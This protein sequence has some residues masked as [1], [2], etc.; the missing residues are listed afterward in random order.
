[1][2]VAAGGRLTTQRPELILPP[3]FDGNRNCVQVGLHGPVNLRE[4]PAEFGEHGCI[5][6]PRRLGEGV[7][8]LP[9]SGPK[10]N[11]GDGLNLSGV[12]LVKPS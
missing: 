3:I 2:Q 6:W 7:A 12:S 9:R 10:I 5:F 11:Q 4:C 8:R 1:M